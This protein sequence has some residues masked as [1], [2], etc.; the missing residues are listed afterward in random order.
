MNQFIDRLRTFLIALVAAGSLYTVFILLF[1]T[2]A[3]LPQPMTRIHSGTEETAEITE[4][5]IVP[6]A[7]PLPVDAQSAH[8][9]ILLALEE[10]STPSTAAESYGA[11]LGSFAAPDNVAEL[12][13]AADI[14]AKTAPAVEPLENDS[15]LPPLAKTLV[16]E[17][18]SFETSANDSVVEMNGKTAVE[19][20]EVTAV[21]TA[22]DEGFE[23]VIE[24]V[25][26]SVV[27]APVDAAGNTLDETPVADTSN[28]AVDFF[29]IPAE[30]AAVSE[31]IDFF[32]IPVFETS[33]AP[34]DTASLNVASQ[35]G[36][37]NK[38]SQL[39]VNIAPPEPTFE[40]TPAVTPE[41]EPVVINEEPFEFMPVSLSAEKESP[42]VSKAVNSLELVEPAEAAPQVTASEPADEEPAATENETASVTEESAATEQE[43]SAVAEGSTAADNESSAAVANESAITFDAESS[44]PNAVWYVDSAQ[45]TNNPETLC[46]WR[47]ADTGFVAS[48]LAAFIADESPNVATVVVI[49]GNLT[50]SR[51]AVQYGMTAAYRL[52]R[53]QSRRDVQTGFRL[54]IWKWPSEKTFKG[55][56][57]DSQYK[58]SLADRNGAALAGLLAALDTQ[59]HITLIGFSFGARVAGSALTLLGGGQVNG[60][61]LPAEQIADANRSQYN[62]ILLAAA[63]NCGDFSPCGKYAASLPLLDQVL[64]VYNPIDKALKFYPLLY[65]GYSA[66][67][68]G[69]APMAGT[70]GSLNSAAQ[71]RSIN[72]SIFGPEHHFRNYFSSVADIY[73]DAI[74]FDEPFQQ[75]ASAEPIFKE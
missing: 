21:E 49:H 1:G 41:D 40:L 66:R 58:A 69:T 6:I 56:R 75:T 39:S 65:K 30:M 46:F 4:Q 34:Q 44:A 15:P 32:D 12:P 42:P 37:Q 67:A 70:F 54:V 43:P 22:A 5:K 68:V 74:V 23:M 33:S 18:P 36:P 64:N 28:E 7:T 14:Q 2:E 3:R 38:P 51:A 55:I 17:T 50:D 72:A 29:N 27:E 13:S 35:D 57:P 11:S 19:P 63:A 60:A 52:E 48:D 73:L 25:A 9:E 8:D 47:L 20:T 24:S 26:D 16:A 53:I 59:S 61:A 31:P 62:L 10:Q 45:A 71:I